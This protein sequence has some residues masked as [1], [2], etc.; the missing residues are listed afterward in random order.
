MTGIETA[1]AAGMG[2][3]TVAV[4]LLGKAGV[5]RLWNGRA[6]PSTKPGEAE[7]CRER[8]ELLARIDERLK[9]ISDG[10]EALKERGKP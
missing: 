10:V 7:I 4:G 9:S 6:G 8:G 2:A 5:M 1:I 3:G